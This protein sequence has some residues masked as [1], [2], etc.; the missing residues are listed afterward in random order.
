M[1][2]LKLPDGV[3]A[4]AHGSYSFVVDEDGCIDTGDAPNEVVAALIAHAGATEPP[5]D[6]EPKSDL[7][8]IQAEGAA[9][10]KTEK[11]QLLELLK[12]AGVDDVDGRK[13]IAVL[14]ARWA[15][16]Q[17]DEAARNAAKPAA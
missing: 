15:R 2:R 17:S 1:P 3:S 5:A 7:A 16:V 10:L 11:E 13:S 9:A 14:R 6:L 8:A 4:A 12:G